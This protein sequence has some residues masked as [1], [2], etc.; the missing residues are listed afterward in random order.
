MTTNDPAVIA[1]KMIELV[2][3]QDWAA[4]LELVA[5]NVRVRVG[6]QD[7]DREAWM[8]MG[9]QFYAAFPDAKH[10]I[11]RTIPGGDTVTILATFS[12]THRGE[13]MGIP[14]TGRA[15]AFDVVHVDRVVDGR[16]VEHRGQLDSAGLMQQLTAFDHRA[17]ADKLFSTIDAQQSDK[18]LELLAPT[19]TFTMAGETRDRTAYIELGEMFFAAFPDGRHVNREVI[20]A[21]NRVVVIGDFGGTHR[22]PFMG[23]PATG[24]T[25]SFGYIGV[26]TIAAD[27]RLAKMEVQGDFAGL[28]RQLTA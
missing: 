27:G 19:F 23:V 24:R 6:S 12:G 14:P 18:T 10:T 13:L 9:K 7:M 3:R 22:G 8:A 21:G 2:D 11:Q 17:Y 28:M 26:G 16:I 1:T 5:P 15:I 25:M 4:T 20:G